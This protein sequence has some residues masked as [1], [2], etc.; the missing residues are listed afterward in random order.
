MPYIIG[1]MWYPSHKQGDAVK[2]YLKIRDKYPADESLYEQRCAPVMT[3]EKGIKLMSVWDV[4]AGKLEQALNRTSK[5]YYEF[6]NVEGLE[7]KVE[8]W[9]TFEE[10]IGVAGIDIPE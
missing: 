3:T 7:Y 2:T 6:I 4:K 9:M 1:T 10:A 8:V 5:F